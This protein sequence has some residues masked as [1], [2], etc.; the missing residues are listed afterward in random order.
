MRKYILPL[1]LGIICGLFLTH[2]TARLI[3][4]VSGVT[5]SF[6]DNNTGNYVDWSKDSCK[7]DTGIQGPPGPQ[8]MSGS[9]SQYFKQTLTPK[10]IT[11]VIINLSN[12][13]ITGKFPFLDSINIYADPG[14]NGII[15][16]MTGDDINCTTNPH[17]LGQ[18]MIA[19]SGAT[20]H[21]IA[22][23]TL[24]VGQFM[25]ISITPKSA[26]MTINGGLLWHVQ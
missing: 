6:L 9:P 19:T 18:G 10:T 24:T 20:I 22:D 12:T 13:G 17:I 25:C 2:M 16:V 15:S 23:P 7:G 14:G 26:T 5:Y 11:P 3:A 21:S 8:G 4:Q 1:T